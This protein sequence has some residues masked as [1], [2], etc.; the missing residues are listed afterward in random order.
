MMSF[1]ET[2]EF[3]FNQVPVFQHSGASAYKP[4]LANTEA[5]DNYFN[6]PHHSFKTIHVG[7]T[8][9]K[10]ST[11]HTLAAILQ[12]AG[13]KVGLYTSPHLV[14]F[15]ERIRVNGQMLPKQYVIEFVANHYSNIEHIHP[16]FFELTMMMAFC[17]FREAKV[18]VAI[19]EVGLGGRLDS[20]NIL[21]PELSVITNISFD[22]VQFLGNSL[23]EIAAEKAGIMKTGIPVIIGEAVG[24][25]KEVFKQKA[26]EQ[27]SPLYFAEESGI[28][29]KAEQTPQ[30]E[31]LYQTALYPDLIGELGGECQQKNALTILT[32]LSLLKNF[33]IPKEAVYKGF[34][35][36]TELTG[37]QGR[38]QKIKNI[39]LTYCDTAHN[40]G[41][42]EYIVNQLS[43]QK[44]KKLRIVLGMANDK[45][46]TGILALLP[47]KAHYYFT[48]ASVNRAMEADQLKS[49]AQDAALKGE[50]FP[51]VESAYKAAL[52]ESD[53]NDFIFI[54][55]SNF[56]IA[57]LLQII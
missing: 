28:L 7:G 33:N 24:E 53:A 54:G 13:Y 41:G 14:D 9:G 49:L 11:S 16:S 45:D 3:L 6:H 21:T 12:E 46:I 23:P 8:N 10:G 36:V 47:K 25:V 37:L 35:N 2:T 19:I 34:K 20:T 22:H 27:N 38:W 15:R 18:D 55:G 51:T 29:S 50:A 39:P 48:K 40:K 4:G 56:V 26:I 30:G 52:N 42:I 43:K 57:D 32:T 1:E 17:Y 44:Y 31:W 5:L